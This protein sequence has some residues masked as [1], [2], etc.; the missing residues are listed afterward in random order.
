MQL[1]TIRRRLLQPQNLLWL[2]FPL[3]LWWAMWRVPIR[4]ILAILQGLRWWS[5]LIL[6]VANTAILALF[7]ARWWLILRAQGYRVPYL[8]LSAYRLAA[9]GVTYVTPGPQMGGEPL[10]AYLL[11]RRSSISGAEAIASVMLDKLLELLASFTFL[12]LGIGTILGTGLLFPEIGTSVLL[13][14][15]G[16]VALPAGY[17]FVLWRGKTPLSSLARWF[18]ERFSRDRFARLTKLARTSE[19]QVAR[20]LD[21]SPGTVFKSILLSFF[22][23]IAIVFEFRLA[24]SFL[25]I[26]MTFPQVIVALTAARIAFLLP[27]PAGLGTLEAG[28]VLAMQALGFNPAIGIS[29]SLLIRARDVIFGGLGL[30]LGG[31]LSR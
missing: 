22:I 20:F 1:K 18:S 19:V 15:L 31:V 30:W 24:L 13:L 26:Q 27:I 23:W 11:H 29:I 6:V 3:L 9:F 12:L 16:L 14:P 4:E 7:S 8:S 2:A 5:I 17:L 25:G 28:Q 10:Q 21:N